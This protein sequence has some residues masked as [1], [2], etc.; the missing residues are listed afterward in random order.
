MAYIK[1]IKPITSPP[2]CELFYCAEMPQFLQVVGATAFFNILSS[3]RRLQA[4]LDL[5]IISDTSLSDF[6]FFF[7][8][9]QLLPVQN[10]VFN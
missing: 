6:F 3:R 4:S 9:K 10:V 7:F 1:S 8:T 5:A 2:G